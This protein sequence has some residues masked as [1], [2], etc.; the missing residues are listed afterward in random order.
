MQLLFMLN[1]A[2][3]N[4]RGRPLRSRY[5]N[6]F[7]SRKLNRLNVTSGLQAIIE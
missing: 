6:I 1:A 3:K 7:L 5:E 2:M 4:K